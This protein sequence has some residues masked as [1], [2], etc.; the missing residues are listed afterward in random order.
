VKIKVDSSS[1]AR[2][3][4]AIIYPLDDSFGKHLAFTVGV[5]SFILISHYWDRVGGTTLNDRDVYPP[6]VL[7]QCYSPL[8]PILGALAEQTPQCY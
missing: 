3:N 8:A 6:S 7:P 4:K 1:F 5:N 2:T